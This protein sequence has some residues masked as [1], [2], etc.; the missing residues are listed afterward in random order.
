MA[1]PFALLLLAPLSVKL[2]LSTE[3]KSP[4]INIAPPPSL[5]VD[6]NAFVFSKLESSISALIPSI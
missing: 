6:P 3:A 2:D 4:L 5:V 1:P